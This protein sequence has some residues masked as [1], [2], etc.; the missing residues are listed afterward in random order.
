[1]A[2]MELA[3]M[4]KQLEELMEKGSIRPNSLPWGY[5]FIFVKNKNDTLCMCVN[6]RPLSTI[7]V[8]N[9]DGTFLPWRTVTR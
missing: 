6:Y 2:L 7:T 9:G 4:K 3:E 1:M 5:S 8:K